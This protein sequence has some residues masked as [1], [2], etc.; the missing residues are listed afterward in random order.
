MIRHVTTDYCHYVTY[1]QLH[2]HWLLLITVMHVIDKTIG[3]L[4]IRYT[5]TCTLVITWSMCLTERQNRYLREGVWYDIT[6]RYAAF[7]ARFKSWEFADYI[8]DHYTVYGCD[9]APE[10][11]A[12]SPQQGPT[13]TNAAESLHSR[14]NADIK[15]PHPN[16]YV[17]LQRLTHQQATTYILTGSSAFTRAPSRTRSQKA[18]QLQQLLQRVRNASN[19][20]TAVLLTALS[21]VRPSRRPS[22]TFRCFVETNEATIMR[23]SPSDSKII[24]VS[25]EV[26]IVGK[27][28]GD[29]P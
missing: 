3:R 17:F 23:F 20:G 16:I 29:H 21:A 15:T 26:K 4:L 8:V 11:W 25:G 10:L 12:A 9:F 2:R 22:V 19:A 27:F 14:L 7:N 18:A 1:R 6:M 5:R 24:L 13:T 28:A